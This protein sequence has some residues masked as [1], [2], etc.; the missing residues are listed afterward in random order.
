[1]A[2]NY[3]ESTHR[4][5][6]ESIAEKFG[7]TPEYVYSLAHGM[8]STTHLDNEILE[9]LE[10]K[11][12]VQVSKHRHHHKHHHHSLV[13]SEHK[14]LIWNILFIVFVIA[15]IYFIR[16]ISHMDLS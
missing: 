4:E 7:T 9:L 13:G 14:R 10:K 5:Q 3:K 16:K 12:I 8:K 1:M 6:Y 11:H 15:A 2:N